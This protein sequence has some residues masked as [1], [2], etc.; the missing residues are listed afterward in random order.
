MRNH[1]LSTRIALVAL[2]A[3]VV[4]PGVQGMEPVEARKRPRTIARTFSNPA[5]IT[6][7]TSDSTVGSVVASPYPAAIAVRGLKGE[8]R[9]VNLRLNGLDHPYVDEVEVLLVGPRGQTAIVMANVGDFDPFADPVT[10]LLDDEAAAPLPDETTVQSRAYRPTI[11]SGM[12][13][14]FA[15]P[16]PNP[17]ANTRL[18]VFDGGNPN[19]TWRLF[20][21]DEY[22]WT[23]HGAI[24]GGWELEITTKTKTRKRR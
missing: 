19:G 17:S 8:I 6:I 16:A 22:G 4:L 2:T 23:D 13:V 14:P 5:T 12:I 20:V 18:S 7:P 10:L 15:A 21:Q 11:G 1:T 24:T 3:L 9:D